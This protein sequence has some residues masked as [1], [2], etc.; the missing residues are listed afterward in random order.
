[1]KY[2]QSIVI[3]ALASMILGLT[4]CQNDDTST[5]V[6]K[7]AMPSTGEVITSSPGKPTAPISISY[8]IL[9]NAIVGQPVLINVVIRSAEGPVN[10]EYSIVDG[11]AMVFQSGQVERLEIADP[12]LSNVQQL[13]VIPQREGRMYVNVSAQVQAPIGLA[14]R[15]IAIPI[16]VGRALKETSSNGEL[17]EGPDGEIVI[18]LPAQPSD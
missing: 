7:P 1:M 12:S 15:S 3:P 18:S 6:A 5:Q 4:A 13:S 10:V 14:I 11:S 17:V 2:R 16:K 8:E 9:G